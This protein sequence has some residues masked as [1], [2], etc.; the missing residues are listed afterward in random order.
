MEQA[1]IDLLYEKY[2]AWSLKTVHSESV[3]Q[4]ALKNGLAQVCITVANRI[5]IHD[6]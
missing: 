1:W 5:Y 4:V 6:N 3:K 2:K